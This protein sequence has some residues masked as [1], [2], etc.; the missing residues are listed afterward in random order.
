MKRTFSL[1]YFI[2]RMEKQK[3]TLTEHPCGFFQVMPIPSTEELSAYYSNRY[4]QESTTVTYAKEYSIDEME[5]INNRNIV[6]EAVYHRIAG[7]NKGSF[8]DVGCGEGFFV[9]YLHHQ[10]WTVRACDFSNYGVKLHN[11]D[12]LPYFEQGDIFEILDNSISRLEKYDFI[13]L[14]NVLEHVRQPME[15]LE[16]L[17]N[18]MYPTSILCIQVPNDYSDYQ[19][20]L[21]D[22]ELSKESWFLPPDHLN[23]FTFNSLRVAITQASFKEKITITDFQIEL[24][25]ANPHSNYVL[26]RSKGK[27]AHQARIL[28]DNYLV[29][30]GVDNY[31]NY[32]A[33]AAA[34]NFG[35]SI[36]M[37]LSLH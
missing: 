13:Y 9:G 32:M 25:Q 37:F 35:R 12:I 15:L 17:R 23:Y 1:K 3:Y 10:G 27:Q 11:P 4:Y 14:S 2:V 28:T 31:I 29:R 16:N 33:A 22:K 30:Q 36:L 26:N 21:V 24:F 7:Q 6:S 19:K 34:C 20:L 18:I 5:Y 8:L